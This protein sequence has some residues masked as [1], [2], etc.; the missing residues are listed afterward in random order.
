VVR[1][2]V[3]P[4]HHW[5]ASVI[6]GPFDLHTAALTREGDFVGDYEGLEAVP[7]GFVAL[8]AMAKPEAKLGATDVFFSRITLPPEG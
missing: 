4:R 2:V 3:R 1:V 8:Y 7:G 6:A 5:H